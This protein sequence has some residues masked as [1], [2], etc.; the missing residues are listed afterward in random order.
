MCVGLPK[1][2]AATVHAML[3]ETWRNADR[4]GNSLAALLTD[5]SKCFHTVSVAQ[6]T[7]FLRKTGMPDNVGKFI[8]ISTEKPV[9]NLSTKRRGG[10]REREREREREKQQKIDR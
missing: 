10:K 6:A 2:S 5:L 3:R 8:W 4:D 7:L 9:D 1:I